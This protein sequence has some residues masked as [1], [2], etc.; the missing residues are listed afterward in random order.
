MIIWGSRSMTGT[1]QSG[2]FAC[3]RC[4]G[5]SPFEEKRV[6]RWFTLYFLPVFPI[7][8]SGYYVECQACRGTFKPEV[9]TYS[10]IKPKAAV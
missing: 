2:R 5:Q 3:P 1:V 8:S 7:G 10:G 4:N 9:L 6:R